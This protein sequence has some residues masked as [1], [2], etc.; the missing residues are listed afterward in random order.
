MANRIFVGIAAAFFT[1]SL[2]SRA[3]AVCWNCGGDMCPYGLC[4]GTQGEGWVSCGEACSCTWVNPDCRIG[5]P[6]VLAQRVAC[7]GSGEPIHASFADFR[8]RGRANRWDLS[9]VAVPDTA[10]ING[11]ARAGGWDVRSV[12]RGSPA[13]DAGLR[14]GDLIVKMDGRPVQ[15]IPDLELIQVLDNSPRGVRLEAVRGGQLLSVTLRSTP[16]DAISAHIA[17]ERRGTSLL[18]PRAGKG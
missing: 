15:G 4:Y 2:A 14:A 11:V 18:G 12:L 10:G 3:E 16:I 1:L 17:V 5:S 8:D 13:W 6:S 7:T 9:M